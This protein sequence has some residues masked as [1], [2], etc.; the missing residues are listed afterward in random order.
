M[1]I[2][3]WNI[4]NSISTTEPFI[5]NWNADVYILLEAGNAEDTKRLAGADNYHHISD[6]FN[7][8]IISKHPIKSCEDIRHPNLS[9]P[10]LTCKI[11]IQSLDITFIVVHLIMPV[12]NHSK[13]IAQ[14]KEIAFL[15]SLLNNNQTNTVV[16]GDLN[17]RSELDGET[18]YI[19]A[20]RMLSSLGFVDCAHAKQGVAFQA[21]KIDRS[22]TGKRI[23][24][25]F[26]SPDLAKHF[27]NYAVQETGADISDHRAICIDLNLS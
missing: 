12:D 23:D 21:T 18:E 2:Q 5:L 15:E 22:N 25:C 1:R 27:S 8:A 11:T 26:L 9:K 4:A 13:Q 20:T 6:A 17:A 10:F 3:S 14:T 19:E 7:M 24:Y 16:I